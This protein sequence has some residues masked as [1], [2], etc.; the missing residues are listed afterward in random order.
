MDEL[1]ISQDILDEPTTLECVLLEWSNT[2][3]LLP[4]VLMVEAFVFDQQHF[5]PPQASDRQR[6]LGYYRWRDMD[7]PVISLNVKGIDIREKPHLKIAILHIKRDGS[8]KH[9]FLAIC[10]ENDAKQITVRESELSWEDPLQYTALLTQP[11][12]TQTVVIFQSE[13]VLV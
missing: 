12:L 4:L 13:K 7:I 1:S 10:F 6:Y 11:R 2:V 3:Y 5:I 8:E 9:P